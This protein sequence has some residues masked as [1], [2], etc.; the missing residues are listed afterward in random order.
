MP[1]NQGRAPTMCRMGGGNLV[2]YRKSSCK[3]N[4]QPFHKAGR[5]IKTVPMAMGWFIL[6]QLP[7]A[8]FCPSLKYLSEAHNLLDPNCTD[9][10]SKQP[11]DTEKPARQVQNWNETSEIIWDSSQKKCDTSQTRRHNWMHGDLRWLEQK[12]FIQTWCLCRGRGGGPLTPFIN[13][14]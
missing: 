10:K 14:T 6:T 1:A 3:F 7:L 13:S 4:T 12:K 5:Q 9:L 11:E 2:R 8:K